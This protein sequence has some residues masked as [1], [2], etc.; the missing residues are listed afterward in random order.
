[1]PEAGA[2]KR[3]IV[4]EKEILEAEVLGEPLDRALDLRQQCVL[5]GSVALLT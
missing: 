4:L 2:Q 3:M 1:M 5:I